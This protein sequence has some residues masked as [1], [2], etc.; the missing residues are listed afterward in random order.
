MNRRNFIKNMAATAGSVSPLMKIGGG[1]GLLS[2]ATMASSIPTDGFKAIVVI[3]LNGGSDSMNTFIPTA[4]DTHAQ[5]KAIRTSLGIE[6]EDL[7]KSDFYK[8]DDKGHYAVEAGDANGDKQPYWPDDGHGLGTEANKDGQYR[9]GSYHTKSHP[10]D[11]SEGEATGLGIHAFMPELAALYD[12]KKLSIVSGVG[13]LVEPTFNEDGKIAGAKHPPFLFSHSHQSIA[14]STLT[15]E[16]LNRTGWAGRLADKWSSDGTNKINGDIGLNLS[17]SGGGNIFHGKFT[18][19]LNLTSTGLP[20]YSIGNDYINKVYETVSE[21]NNFDR[22]YNKQLS[23]QAKFIDFMNDTW[24]TAPNFD[25]Y[26][27]KNAY[28]R[29]L[30]DVGES[31]LKYRQLLGMRTHHGLH[32]DLLNSFRDTAKMLKL[33]RD[34]FGNNRQVLYI[35]Q[36]GYDYHGGQLA[37]Q[38]KHLRTMSMAVSDFYKALEEMGMEKEVLVIQTSDFG[39]TMMSNNDGTDHG[40]G[41]HGFMLCGD[42]K[43]NGGNVFGRVMEDV[44]LEGPYAVTDRARILPSTAM[45]QMYAPALKWFGV[46]EAT[47]AHVLPNLKN[48]RTDAS[49]SESAFL[50][51]VFS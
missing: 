44:S 18:S 7:S 27:A 33:S 9:L 48:F 2:S 11:G 14:V 25:T 35:D 47:M 16:A 51:G 21:E 22:V 37:A 26:T 42:P 6:R 12:N 28:G 19:G 41:G 31:A 38:T 3:N 40:W 30:F 1:L 4:E 20:K 8:T 5:Y 32:D 43:F 13:I 46:D 50:Q 49:D 23:R 39:R 45:E 10:I 15:W 24:T 34:T 36:G 17:F 29:N